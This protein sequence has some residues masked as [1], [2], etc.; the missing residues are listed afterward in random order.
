MIE[1]LFTELSQSQIKD[2]AREKS[3]KSSG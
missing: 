3:L 1:L 2:I